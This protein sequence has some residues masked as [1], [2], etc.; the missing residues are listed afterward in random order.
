MAPRWATVEAQK[1]TVGHQ[2]DALDGKSLQHLAQHALQGLRLRD[3]AGMN[4]VHERQ[5]FGGLYHAQNELA[6]D[7]AGLLV[8]A[9]GTQVILNRPFAM[10][11]HRGQVVEDDG[12]IPVDQGAYLPRQ[13]LFNRIRMIHQRVHGAQQMLVCDG[14]RDRRH[15]HRFQPAQASQLAVRSTKAVEH[16]GPDQRF[17]IE[18]A[19][20]GAQRFPQGNVEA[21]VLPQLVQ[22]K[23]IA[24]SEGGLVDH[25]G[26]GILDAPHGAVQAID[27][28]IELAAVQPVKPPKVRDHLDAHLASLVAMALDELQ[29]APAARLRDA[30]VHGP[31]LRALRQWLQGDCHQSV[32]Q[33]DLPGSACSKPPTH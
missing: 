17:G 26:G 30:R 22:C 10:D 19:S 25:I 27:Q 2:D 28:R 23:D 9:E 15:R 3:I 1:A 33:Q 4:R 20:R 32:L 21:Q 29:I 31:T 11:A 16:H 14:L 7:A 12:E 8:H 13:S 6:R 5:A 18:L 24:V